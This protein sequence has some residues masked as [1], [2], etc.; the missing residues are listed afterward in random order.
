M[1]QGIWLTGLVMGLALGVRA[2]WI[3]VA[4]QRTTGITLLDDQAGVQRVVCELAGFD[5]EPVA[6]EGRVYQRLRVPGAALTLEAGAPELPV[7]ATSLRIAD[8]G[9]TR[10]RVLSEE[11]V[12]LALEVLPSKGNLTRDVNPARVPHRFGPAYQLAAWPA[13]SAFLR[14]PY[15]L[16]DV[17]GQS[18]VFQPFQVL[19]SL[20]LLRVFTRLEV[21]VAAAPG[22]GLNELP[23]GARQPGPDAN[24]AQIYQERFLNAGTGERYIPVGE[25]GRLLIICHDTFLEEMAPFVEWKLQRG[26]EVV[27]LPKS[28]VGTTSTAIRNFVSA[29]YTDPGLAYLLLVGDAE[30]LPSPS[31]SGGASDPTYAMVAGTD[32][33]P[34]ILVGRFSASTEAQVATMVER[35]VE[36]ERDP[37]PGADWYHRGMGIGSAEGAG[38]GDDGES[39]RQHIANIRTDLLGYGYDLV[40]GIYDPGATAAA[41][42]TGL[43]SG[44]SIIN[45]VGHGATTSWVTTGFANSHVNALA[46]ENRLPFIFDVACVNGQFSGTTCFAEAWMRATHNGQP[47]GAVGIYA[48]TI[49]QSWAPPMAAQDE[50]VDL[51]VAESKLSFGG[52]CYNGAMRMNDEYADYAMTRTWTIF[53]DPSLQVRTRTPQPL[54]LSHPAVLPVGQPDFAVQTDR[55]GARAALYADGQLL[56]TALA[57]ESGLALVPVDV[58]PAAGSWVTLTL[59]AHNGLTRQASLLAVPADAPWLSGSDARLDG[60]AAARPGGSGWLGLSVHNLGGLAAQDLS[61]SLASPHPAVSVLEGQPQVALLE[62]GGQVEL[63][64]AFHLQ[65]GDSLLD[66][67]ALPLLLQ[68]QCAGGLEFTSELW[69]TAQVDPRL[70]CPGTELAFATA[71]GAAD[72][73]YLE[74][75]NSG[76]AELQFTLDTGERELAWLTTTPASGRLA[77]GEQVA[78]LLRADSAGLPEGLQL[79]RLTLASNDPD[80]P[81]REL[82]LSLLVGGLSPV[83]DLGIELPG[84]G[85]VHLAWSPV[86]GARSYRVWQRGA[87]PGWTL[88]L[89]S[90]A[91]EC[92][93]PCQVPATRSYRVT[94]VTE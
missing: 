11:H 75:G 68:I 41:V 55:P 3:E 13:E 10:L 48:S 84:D 70:D 47:S 50:M 90:P 37:Q 93:L 18:L 36:Y 82:P 80:Q 34:D 51:L 85:R 72:S 26:Q 20:G 79:G 5:A 42:T 16:R 30:Q 38:I 91:T 77:P 65:F 2:E 57:D 61:L 89:E 43:N 45:Y 81:L 35:C 40:D 58:A 7:L 67:E 23:S 86:A 88:V 19:P 64:Q 32:S 27:L 73:L 92:V 87:L 21:E 6:L 8:Q 62:A 46:N 60:D 76:D 54:A 59:T 15:I 74:L 63:A 14:E 17:R 4:A 44:R 69:L 56:G 24:F 12:D 52:L 29:Y 33:Y 28:Q 31:H 49:N 9:A 66:G 25:E 1:R 94:A 22:A 53:T 83:G 71:P 78:V 39:D